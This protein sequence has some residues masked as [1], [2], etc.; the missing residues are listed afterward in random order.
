MAKV[1]IRMVRWMRPMDG[2]VVVVAPF[3]LAKGF[4]CCC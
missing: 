2:T 4:L 3:S 1:S